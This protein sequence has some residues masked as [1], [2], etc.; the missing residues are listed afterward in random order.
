MRVLWVLLASWC[1]YG[2]AL[3][4]VVQLIAGV[5]ALR[6]WSSPS[7]ARDNTVS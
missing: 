1:L 5:I 4:P 3:L 7:S 6:C 2:L